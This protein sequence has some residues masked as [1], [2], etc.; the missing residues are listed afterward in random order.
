MNSTHP[1]SF[2]KGNVFSLGKLVNE[3]I[4]KHRT[5]A[6]HYHNLLINEIAESE[7][8]TVHAD[9]AVVDAVIDGLIKAFVTHTRE[10]QINI[11]ARALYGKMIEVSI[12]DDHC[13]NTYAM[14]ISLQEIVPLAEQIGGQISITHQKQ[15]MTAVSF[16]F[17]PG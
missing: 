13:K 4:Q 16:R 2:D 15:T 3:N 12:K 7:A 8:V 17:I 10:S 14:A 1:V 5:A 6:E 11:S 9:K